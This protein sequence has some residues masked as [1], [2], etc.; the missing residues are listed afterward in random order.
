[1][2]IKIVRDDP[3]FYGHLVIGGYKL[4]VSQYIFSNRVPYNSMNHPFPYVFWVH[5]PKDGQECNAIVDFVESNKDRIKNEFGLEFEFE[6]DGKVLVEND[7]PK[8]SKIFGIDGIVTRQDVLSKYREL[9][10]QY[11]PDRLPNATEEEKKAAEE[12]FKE[13]TA[14]YDVLKEIDYDN[15]VSAV[16][17]TDLRQKR[18]HELYESNLVEEKNNRIA[19]LV[20]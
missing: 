5:F 14:A 8:E 7:F 12:K 19:S 18:L 4:E 10:L 2:D 20:W 3:V 6:R 17:V 15:E 16:Y 13:I 11:H 9:S 1:M